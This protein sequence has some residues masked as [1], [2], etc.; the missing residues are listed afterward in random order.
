MDSATG[1][2]HT[3]EHSNEHFQRLAK[4]RINRMENEAQLYTAGSTKKSRKPQNTTSEILENR[5]QQQK[6]P[7]KTLRTKRNQEL[8]LGQWNID[9][10]SLT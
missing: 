2:K 5:R 9:K 7:H 1:T 10:K 8:D 3:S 4:L 6:Y